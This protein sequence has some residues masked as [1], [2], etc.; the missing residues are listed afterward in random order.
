[1]L[2][3]FSILLNIDVIYKYHDVAHLVNCLVLC[4]KDCADSYALYSTYLGILVTYCL[5]IN[6]LWNNILNTD[7]PVCQVPVHGIFPDGY[8]LLK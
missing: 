3:V 8:E 4:R 2:G 1:M 6:L 7:I 5:K